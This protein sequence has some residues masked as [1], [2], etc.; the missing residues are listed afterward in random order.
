MFQPLK[1]IRIPRRYHRPPSAKD[2]SPL[3]VEHPIMEFERRDFVC[4]G[5]ALSIYECLTPGC[6]GCGC[7][8]FPTDAAWVPWYI[9]NRLAGHAVMCEGLVRSKVP[10]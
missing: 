1:V 7:P 2:V 3:L 4:A 6:R 10:Q 9:G 8:T 5:K